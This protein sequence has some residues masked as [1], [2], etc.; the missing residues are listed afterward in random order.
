[1]ALFVQIQKIH[2]AKNELGMSK[3]EYL[4]FLSNWDVTTSKD[5]SIADADEALI[6]L[7]EQGWVPKRAKSTNVTQQARKHGKTYEAQ[8][9]YEE[10]KNRSS[11]FAAPQQLR[12]IE[13]LWKIVARNTSDEARDKFIL[14]QTKVRKLDWLKKPHAEAVLCALEDMYRK[15]PV[16]Q[17]AE[18]TDLLIPKDAQFVKENLIKIRGV[19]HG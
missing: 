9:K 5:L 14:R 11:D 17:I 3:D 16:A 7:E 15:L 6:R 2:I 19:K 13:I 4:Q 8:R 1:M 18:R 12:L 10:Y